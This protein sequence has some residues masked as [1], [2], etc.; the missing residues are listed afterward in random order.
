[1]TLTTALAILACGLGTFLL[2]YLPLVLQDRRTGT[3][4]APGGMAARWLRAVGPA[5]ITALLVASVWPYLADED[6]PTRQVA[7]LLALATV[8]CVKRWRGGI[9]LPTL[10]GAAVFALAPVV[11]G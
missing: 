11:L 1:M 10:A 4:V 5:A 6:A 3:D 2:R 9:A 8:Y 7:A